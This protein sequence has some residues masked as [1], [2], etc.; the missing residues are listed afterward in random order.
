MVY[1]FL[2]GLT[3]ADIAFEASGKTL[4]ELFESAALALFDIMADP[5]KVSKKIKTK[6]SIEKNNLEDLM[7]SFLEEIIFVKDKNALVFSSCKVEI[8]CAKKN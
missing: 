5:K 1:K 7:F 8:N 3:T 4:S 2:E 6:I